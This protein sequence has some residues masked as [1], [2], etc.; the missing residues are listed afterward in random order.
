MQ[1]GYHL[2]DCFWDSQFVR[3]PQS[4]TLLALTE[5]IK[6]YHLAPILRRFGSWAVTEHG[7]ECLVWF[8]DI[9][10][11]RLWES[12]DSYPWERHLCMKRWVTPE[13]AMAALAYARELW[14]K[15]AERRSA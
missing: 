5:A 10:K 12:F 1:T 2:N 11:A 8:Y 13:D 7:V 9:P 15:D 6:R 4:G 3:L 14:P